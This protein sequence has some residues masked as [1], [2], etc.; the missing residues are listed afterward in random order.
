[1]SRIGRLPITISDDVNV[2]ID[3]GRVLVK[4]SKGELTLNVK[5]NIEVTIEDNKVIVKRLN[6]SRQNRAYHG[7]YRSLIANMVEGVEKGF[8]KEL[9]MSGVGYKAKM[10]GKILVLQVG[11]SHS[12]KYD[13][14]EDVE[15]KVLQETKITV[16]GI[17]K[18]LVGQVAARI[19]KVKPCEPYKGKGIKYVGEIIKRKAGKSAKAAV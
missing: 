4:G 5:G 16:F 13:I 19:R 3:G 10:N 8:L 2:K 14:P 17:D 15:V 18:E 1:M 12:V 9:E 11:Y 7:L 6:E